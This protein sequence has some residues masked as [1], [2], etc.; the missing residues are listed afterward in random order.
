METKIDTCASHSLQIYSSFDNV[1][2]SSMIT[3]HSGFALFWNNSLSLNF[4]FTGTIYVVCETNHLMVSNEK[5]ILSCVYILPYYPNKNNN[6]LSL[7]NIL[8]NSHKPWVLIGDQNDITTQ[9]TS[10]V[11]FISLV[12]LETY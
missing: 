11:M 7:F 3:R 8:H 10:K 1:F 2:V 5:I 4:L 12:P 6:W 9:K